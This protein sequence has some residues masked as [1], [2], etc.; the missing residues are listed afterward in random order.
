MSGPFFFA[1]ADEGATFDEGTM[2]VMDED[3]FDL[4]VKHDEGQ[5]ACSK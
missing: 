2:L 1:W 4:H 3:I 5:Y